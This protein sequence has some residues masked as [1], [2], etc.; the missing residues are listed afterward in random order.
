MVAVMGY[1]YRRQG[2][3]RPVTHRLDCRACKRRTTS[4]TSHLASWSSQLAGML[5]G[6]PYGLPGRVGK[7][8]GW[9][10]RPDA[11]TAGSERV[12]RPC[13]SQAASRVCRLRQVLRGGARSGGPAAPYAG[14]FG[15][16]GESP[17]EP[18]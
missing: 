13:G 4:A 14:P 17:R 8:M 1:P 2:F 16:S 7:P 10:I 15:F 9:L 6:G 11:T 3:D 5:P 12:Y 18:S